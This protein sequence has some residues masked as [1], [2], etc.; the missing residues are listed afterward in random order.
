[1]GPF[2]NP[3]QILDGTF[4]AWA[5]LLSLLF[6]PSAAESLK[7]IS[8]AD[9][10]TRA[11]FFGLPWATAVSRDRSNYDSWVPGSPST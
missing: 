5:K 7:G 2:K 9:P 3:A 8:F 10:I 4:D 1:L 11:L 6:T